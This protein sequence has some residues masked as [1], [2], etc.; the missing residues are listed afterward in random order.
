MVPIGSVRYSIWFGHCKGFLDIFV[1]MREDF[2]QNARRHRG[3]PGAAPE[4]SGK[5]SGVLPEDIGAALPEI[6][7]S[8]GP[9]PGSA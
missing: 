6:G 4:A 2:R 3:S 1:K 8:P 7:L 5:I 9:S